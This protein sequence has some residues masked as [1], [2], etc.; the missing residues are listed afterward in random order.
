METLGNLLSFVRSAEAGSFSAAA[1][2]LGLTPAAVSRNIAQLEANLGVR[3]F[4]RSTRKLTLTEAGERFLANL[5]FGLEAVQAAIDDMASHAHEPAGVL[6]VSAAPGFGREFLLPLMPEF[7]QRYPKVIP[8]WTFENRQVDLVAEG[9]DAAIGGGIELAQGQVARSIA[10]AHLVLVASPGYL[11]KRGPIRKLEALAELDHLAMRSVQ[12]GKVR[13]WMLQGADGQ[14]SPLELRPRLLVDDPEALCQCARLGLGI[15]LLAMPDVL[16]YL[17]DG[18]LERVLPKWYVDAGQ[19]YLYFPSQKL[20]PAKTRAFV[21][22]VVG[23]ARER[24][25][26]IALDARRR[27]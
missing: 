14:Q 3:L 26:A 13:S 9:F 15:A 10:P 7:L 24:A 1:R 8:D 12:T 22:F 21:D 2:R 18:S 27:G 16:P 20:L 19:I 4:Q 23:W 25:W 17:Q 6:R 11:S 5:G